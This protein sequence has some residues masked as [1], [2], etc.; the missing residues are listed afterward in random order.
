[1]NGENS[2]EVPGPDVNPGDAGPPG[3]AGTGED[4]CPVCGGSGKKN[5]RTC[6]NSGGSGKIIQ[7]IGGG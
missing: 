6:A 2:E 1:M 7:G 4:T 5:G 3:T